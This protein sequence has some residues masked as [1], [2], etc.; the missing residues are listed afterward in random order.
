MTDNLLGKQA[1]SWLFEILVQYMAMSHVICAFCDCVCHGQLSA[2]HAS[3][4]GRYRPASNLSAASGVLRQTFS[5]ALQE[6]RLVSLGIKVMPVSCAL[7]RELSLNSC[8]VRGMELSHCMH[9]FHMHIAHCT[10][11]TCILASTACQASHHDAS[12][13]KCV[14][15]LCTVL[16]GKTASPPVHICK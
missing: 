15:M 14:C 1:G 16:T 4:Q 2:V 3:A 8:Q 13:I 6:N 5:R 9:N 11:R 7:L 10:A 12:V